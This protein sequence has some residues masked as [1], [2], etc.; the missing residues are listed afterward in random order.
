MKTKL[1]AIMLLAGS[2]AIAGPRFFFGI[3][4]GAPVY[5]APAPVVAYAPPPPPVTYY[6]PPAPG[7]GYSWI[8]GYWYPAGPRWAWHA[9]YWARRPFIG[10]YWVSPR[11]YGGRYYRGYWRR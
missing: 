9:G 6:A 7:P 4:L 3:N 11:W 5:Y 2:A 10:A 8:A 1:L